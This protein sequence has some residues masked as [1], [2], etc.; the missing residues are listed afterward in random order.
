MLFATR[1]FLPSTKSFFFPLFHL[2]FFHFF[3]VTLFHDS[4]VISRKKKRCKR[5]RA[6]QV[7]LASAAMSLLCFIQGRIHYSKNPPLLSH[8]LPI[9]FYFRRFILPSQPLSSNLSPPKKKQFHHK[10]PLFHTSIPFFL[11]QKRIHETRAKNENNVGKK[12][13]I[14]CNVDSNEDRFKHTTT[15]KRRN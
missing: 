13:R 10:I 2:C 7:Q 1:K 8:S 4:W 3:F 5:P 12:I 9:S 15:K 11:N 14:T 6:R